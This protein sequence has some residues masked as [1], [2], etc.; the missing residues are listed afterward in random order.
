[1]IRDKS[2]QRKIG[3]MLGY[4]NYFIK[5]M[6]QFIYVPIMLSILGKN[7][8]GVYQLV[9]SVISYLSL[10]NFGFGGSYLRFFAQCKGD[11]KKESNLNGTF[12]LLFSFFATLVFVIGV[13]ISVNAK[14]ILGSKLSTEEI[15][16]SKILLFVLAVN[17]AMTFPLSVFSSII[18]SREAFVFQKIM[19]LLKNIAN[20]FGM[21]IVLML[22]K[23]SI[24]LVCVTT[25]ITIAGG[26][27]DIWYVKNKIGAKFTFNRI[28]V[29]LIKEIGVFSF[30][31]FL[32][33]IID[34]INWNVDKYLLGRIV[35]STAIAIY[36]V[37][38]QINTIYIQVSDMTASVMATKVN[39]LVA[40]EANPIKKLDELFLKVGR[41]QSYVIL[42][43]VMGFFVLGRDFIFLWAGREYC[44]AY[45]ITLLLIAPAAVPLM[46]SLGV[47]IQR[48]LNKHRVRSIVYVGLSI[49]NIF[50]SIPLIWKMGGIGA[51]LGTTI[52]LIIGNGIIMNII[53]YKYIGLD[54][55]GFWKKIF[56]IIFTAFVPTIIILI[57]N[58]VWCTISWGS[59]IAKGV[60]FV[61]VYLISEFILAMND[62]EKNVIYKIC[63]IRI[64]GNK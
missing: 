30:F 59:L 27:V 45:W 62:E 52:S 31:I 63:K 9:A 23:G 34:Q 8:Y 48:A 14:T 1:M 61:S 46:Q 20:P 33:S 57:I 11:S 3:V 13:I 2:K 40:S 54:V 21:I 4:V 15:E 41:Y 18:S 44:D 25:I 64:K 26:C 50:V 47:E 37:G 56:P 6:T 39:I 17:M 16:L 7:E 12:L 55:I 53:Y 43:I 29:K 51:A 35:G 58:R 19:E 24:G 22:G 49:I 36:S 42:A 38:A 5:M 60:V 28:E 10:L 32:N